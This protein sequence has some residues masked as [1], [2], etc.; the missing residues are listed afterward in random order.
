MSTWQ[1]VTPGTGSPPLGMD[2]LGQVE[3]RRN[4]PAAKASLTRKRLVSERINLNEFISIARTEG[5]SGRMDITP[6][7]C[8]LPTDRNKPY[9]ILW[10]AVLE[11]FF[12]RLERKFT[13]IETR[14][15]LTRDGFDHIDSSNRT[16]LGIC[17]GYQN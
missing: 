8:L 16:N 10:T 9:P 11:R 7:H 17:L 15:V 12:I 4:A 14:P 3:T 5:V 6:G 13:P 2:P 1:A